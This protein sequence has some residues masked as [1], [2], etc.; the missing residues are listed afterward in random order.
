MLAARVSRGAL[1]RLIRT[2]PD[3]DCSRLRR[4]VSINHST[5]GRHMKTLITILVSGCMALATAGAF[6]QDAM[7]KDAMKKD[8]MK[9]S[10]TKKDAMKKDAMKH[11]TMAKDAMKK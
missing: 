11:D 3:C 1:R 7:K 5:G 9:H 10:T 6:A 4:F 8:E 2:L